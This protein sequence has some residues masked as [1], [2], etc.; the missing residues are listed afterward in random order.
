MY[1][2]EN[3]CKAGYLMKQWVK[4]NREGDYGGGHVSNSKLFIHEVTV[5]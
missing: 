1:Q 5:R 4:N 3:I 2:G